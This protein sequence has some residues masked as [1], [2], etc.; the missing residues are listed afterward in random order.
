MTRRDVGTIRRQPHVTQHFERAQQHG[1][2]RPAGGDT[3]EVRL[4]KPRRRRFD[5]ALHE[6]VVVLTGISSKQLA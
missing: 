2:R 4:A 1:Q 3:L 6:M 5:E